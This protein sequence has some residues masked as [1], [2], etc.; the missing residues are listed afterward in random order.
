MQHHTANPLR[1]TIFWCE[2]G[3]KAMAENST[4]FD[5]V[6]IHPSPLGNESSAPRF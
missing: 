1:G 5:N 4:R 2:P 6:S 3:L